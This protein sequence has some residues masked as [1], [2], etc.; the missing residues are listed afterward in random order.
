MTARASRLACDWG[1]VRALCTRDL[2]RLVRARS[3]WIG[4]VAQPLLFWA[5]LGS[6]MHE[7]FRIAGQPSLSYAEYAFPG[8]VAMVLLFTAVFAT[9][10]VIEDRQSGFL[11]QVLVTPG[12][13]LALIVGKTA[14][15]TAMGLV[16]GLA[17]AAAAPLA[18]LAW[19]SIDWPLLV[20]F[21]VLGLASLTVFNLAAAWVI[22][23]T[24]GYHAVMSVVLLPAWMLS[25]A[26]YPPS[27]GWTVWAMQVNPMTYVV[28][29][30]RQALAP[31]STVATGA[32]L[33][34]ALALCGILGIGVV[35]AHRTV[36]ARAHRAKVS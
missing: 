7:V 30:M 6:G 12:S 14:G 17:C 19:A 1:L 13:H 10:S 16:Q 25:G 35:L 9:M 26:L 34:P 5:V 20:G 29:G 32:V 23:S 22:S 28:A 4:V 11:Q 3:R 21:I 36:R 8:I 2:L 27:S 33:P 15:V 31:A 18:G 24:A